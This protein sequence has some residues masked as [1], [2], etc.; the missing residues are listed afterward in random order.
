MKQW[1]KKEKY[2]EKVGFLVFLCVSFFSRGFL[3][4]H[5]FPIFLQLFCGFLCFLCF[6]HLFVLRFSYVVPSFSSFSRVFFGDSYVFLFVS[7]CFFLCFSYFSRGFLVVFYVFLFFPCFFPFVSYFFPV[8]RHK[9]ILSDR[10]NYSIST[11]SQFLKWS[12]FG[13]GFS[14]RSICRLTSRALIHPNTWILKIWIIGL[15]PHSVGWY[16]GN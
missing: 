4:F 12:K 8:E 16:Y 7:L 5:V 11:I 1:K 13:E 14:H 10:V 15:A 2:G 3:C 9:Y 6:L